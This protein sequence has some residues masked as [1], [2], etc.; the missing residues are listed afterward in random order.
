MPILPIDGY[1][2]MQE[3]KIAKKAKDLLLGVYVE[4]KIKKRIEEYLHDVVSEPLDQTQAEKISAVLNHI[5]KEFKDAGEIYDFRVEHLIDYDSFH[6]KFGVAFKEE[7]YSE[8]IG[9]KF[10]LK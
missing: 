5:M 3:T 10:T 1:Q 7:I 9:M 6:T 8:Y 2:D 4:D